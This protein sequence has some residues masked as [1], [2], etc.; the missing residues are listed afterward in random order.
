MWYVIET[1]AGQEETDCRK[2]KDMLA[3]GDC[4]DLYCVKRKRYLGGWHDKRERFLPG[5]LFV[6]T[7][8]VLHGESRMMEETGILKA[9]EH[10][11]VLFPVK[12]EDEEL[13]MRLTGVD[14][15]VELTHF[16]I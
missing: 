16:F 5:Y 3:E 9:L 14:C 6:V 4:R 2:L 13:L 7:D 8:D 1:K 10:G 11:K 12:H 15:Q